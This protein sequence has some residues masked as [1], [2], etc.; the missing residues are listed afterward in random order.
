MKEDN[1]IDLDT[2]NPKDIGTFQRK[3]DKEKSDDIEREKERQRER[4][5]RRRENNQPVQR[6]D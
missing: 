2:T 6:V 1:W 3:E 5:R 4:E